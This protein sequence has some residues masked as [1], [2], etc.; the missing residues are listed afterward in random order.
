[1]ELREAGLVGK[2]EQFVRKVALTKPKAS[3]ECE[4][5]KRRQTNAQL[6][7]KEKHWTSTQRQLLEGADG[8]AGCMRLSKSGKQRM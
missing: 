8:G 7:L 5:R 1:M 4:N 6:G 2:S 3:T